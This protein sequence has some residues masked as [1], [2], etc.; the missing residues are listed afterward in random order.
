M[1]F[2][3]PINV[4]VRVRVKYI[5]AC[6]GDYGPQARIKGAFDDDPNENEIAYIQAPAADAFSALLR[7]GVIK[8]L[9][10]TLPASR[11]DKLVS[12]PI[13]ARDVVITMAQAQ[14][15]KRPSFTVQRLGATQP[16]AAMPSRTTK[17]RAAPNDYCAE[18]A[19]AAPTPVAA[20]KTR[21]ARTTYSN[22][23]YADIV[24]FVTD[25]IVPR[26]QNGAGIR[27][28]PESIVAAA[29]TLY[30]AETRRGDHR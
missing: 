18:G 13:I 28:T 19:A 29:A 26:V 5:D 14:G 10:E 24:E 30:I 22:P 20:A 7:A 12:V 11:A 27:M 4:P 23:V 2:K 21:A 6:G 8:S 16:R 9:P 1:P 15:E 17:V 25:E 3:F